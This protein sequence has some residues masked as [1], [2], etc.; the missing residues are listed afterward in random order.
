MFRKAFLCASESS[1]ALTDLPNHLIHSFFSPVVILHFQKP[2]PAEYPLEQLL[3]VF[4]CEENRPLDPTLFVLFQYHRGPCFLPTHNQ[5]VYCSPQQGTFASRAAGR[6]AC[7]GRSH[8]P[9]I[10]SHPIPGFPGEVCWVS[11]LPGEKR[12]E[13]SVHQHR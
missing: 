13:R 9:R 6:P 4:T 10:E 7:L 11:P 5:F 2:K 12:A 3:S 8:T 1:F